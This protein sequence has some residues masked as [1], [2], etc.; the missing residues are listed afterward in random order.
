[1]RSTRLPPNLNAATDDIAGVF[2]FS[3]HDHPARPDHS[4]WNSSADTRSLFRT[5]RCRECVLLLPFPC[6]FKLRRLVAVFS[7]LRRVH[8]I[9]PDEDVTQSEAVDGANRSPFHNLDGEVSEGV[10]HLSRPL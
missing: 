6:S 2:R 8:L 4:F 3:A 5:R 10:G 9:K 7:A 1:M